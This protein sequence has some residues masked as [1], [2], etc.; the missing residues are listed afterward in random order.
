ML[1]SIDAFLNEREAISDKRILMQLEDVRIGVAGALAEVDHPA[2]VE[3][4]S[5]ALAANERRPAVV[6]ALAAALAE[7]GWQ[8][9]CPAL[10]SMVKRAGVATGLFGITSGVVGMGCAACGSFLLT[11]MLSFVG[12]SGILAFLPLG[13]GEFG[14]LGVILLG[15]SLYMTAKKIQNPAVVSYSS[16]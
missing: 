7:L 15:I 2:S 6:E 13:G 5:H 10:E 12:A 11:S 9:A 14:I 1:H 8:S 3:V 16:V 4:L